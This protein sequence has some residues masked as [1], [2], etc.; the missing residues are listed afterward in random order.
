MCSQ[1][2]IFGL[3]LLWSI[4]N[5]SIFSVNHRFRIL[6]LKNFI[7]CGWWWVGEEKNQRLHPW[8]RVQIY[9]K[10]SRPVTNHFFK[11]V[12]FWIPGDSGTGQIN[13]G[14]HIVWDQI[15]NTHSLRGGQYLCIKQ[16]ERQIKHPRYC[17]SPR[18]H[19]TQLVSD[20]GVLLS[21][22]TSPLARPGRTERWRIFSILRESCRIRLRA[23]DRMVVLWTG[24][25]CCGRDGNTKDGMAVLWTGWRCCGRDGGAVD[26]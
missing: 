12:L 6:F 19:R 26:A 8:V 16:D 15:M 3:Y 22:D 17:S 18:S 4:K 25:R 10:V 9:G 2:I 11:T 14:I 7:F 23:V 21:P 13:F 24:W 20:L 5:L 1:P